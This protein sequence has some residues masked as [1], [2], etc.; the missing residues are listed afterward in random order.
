MLI[1]EFETRQFEASQGYTVRPCL[2]NKQKG[3]YDI[4]KENPD[5]N[6]TR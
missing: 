4:S 1:S 2:K 5:G 3:A 6:R